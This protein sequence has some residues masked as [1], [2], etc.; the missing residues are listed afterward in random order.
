[1]RYFIDVREPQEYASGHVDNSINLPLT[2]L[3][4]SLPVE[5][6]HD[7]E[8]VVYCRSGTR[9]SVAIELLAQLG[10]HHVVNG[11]NREHVEQ[12]YQ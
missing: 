6:S 3:K 7:D 1:M 9:A 5:I 8:L 2:N 11:I 10:F 4:S 12:T